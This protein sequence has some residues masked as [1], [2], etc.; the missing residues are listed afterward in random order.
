MTEPKWI[1]FREDDPSPGQ[2][3]RT[4]LWHVI[5]RKRGNI[6]GE[7]KWYPGWHR[8]ALFPTPNTVWDEICMRDV[9][10]FCQEQT[11][12]QKRQP[13]QPRRLYEQIPLEAPVEV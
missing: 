4:R 9:A 1:L 6:I 3:R 13:K 2:I 10:E 7:I 5:S 8:Y 12:D 11:N